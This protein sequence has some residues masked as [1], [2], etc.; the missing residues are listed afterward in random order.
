MGEIA[1]GNPEEL[2]LVSLVDTARLLTLGLLLLL[3]DLH[4]LVELL[5][6][7]NHGLLL[8]VCLEIAGDG[9]IINAFEKVEE[10]RW[11][12]VAIFDVELSG[13]WLT[14]CTSDWLIDS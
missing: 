9:P 2:H 8:L 1:D 12:K 4:L 7:L 6:E 14:S 13:R 11:V 5:G 10:A 3:L